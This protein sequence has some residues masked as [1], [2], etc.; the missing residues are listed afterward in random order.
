MQPRVQILNANR[1]VF[2]NSTLPIHSSVSRSVQGIFHNL[3]FARRLHQSRASDLLSLSLLR[4]V[5]SPYSS[6]K[7]INPGV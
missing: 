7:N 3:L 6:T 1:V 2:S 4:L 5:V